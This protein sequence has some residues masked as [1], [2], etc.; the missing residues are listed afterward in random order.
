MSDIGP[1]TQ[2]DPRAKPE[3]VKQTLIHEIES[4]SED[5]DIV[6]LDRDKDMRLPPFLR[7]TENG[8]VDLSFPFTP[9]E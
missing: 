3:H 7:D 8:D 6:K 9:N 2:K 4:P 1:P 5:E